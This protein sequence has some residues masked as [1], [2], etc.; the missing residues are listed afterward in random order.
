MS[1][2]IINISNQTEWMNKWKE[3][4]QKNNNFVF[5]THRIK[6]K[7]NFTTQKTLDDDEPK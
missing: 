1:K 7:K 6:T 5:G 2:I 4:R 3:K